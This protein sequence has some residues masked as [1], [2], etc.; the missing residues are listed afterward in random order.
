M[1]YGFAHWRD[2]TTTSPS[3]KHLGLY[4]AI[5]NAH[6]FKL[7]VKAD[8]N[9]I[10]S[11]IQSELFVTKVLQLQNYIINIAIKHH[12]T[13]ERWKTVHNCFLEKIPGKPLIDKLRVIHIY[14]AD[15]NIILT[16]HPNIIIILMYNY[17]S[18]IINILK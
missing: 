1:I 8:K 9:T 17:H 14:E 15:Y 3:G 16:N 4:K 5:V 10:T 6:K 18:Y 7:Q 11:D 2:K 13:L 12:H